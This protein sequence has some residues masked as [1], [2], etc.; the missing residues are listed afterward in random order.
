MHKGIRLGSVAGI[1]VFIDW[2]LLIIFLLIS[3]SLAAGVFP[4]WHPDWTAQV[5]WITALVAAVLFFASVLAHELA[6]ALVGRMRGIEVRRIT[7]FIFGGLAEMEHEPKAW[8]AELWMA[9]VGPLTSL[10]LGVLFVVLASLVSGPLTFDAEDPQQAFARLSPLATLLVWVGHV[11]IVLALF[12][13]V[14]GFPLD[15]GRILRALLWGW[16]GDPVRATRAAS[17]VGQAFA[18]LLILSGFAMVLGLHVPFFGTGLG[19]LWLAFIGWFLHNAA[20]VSYRQLLLRE[21]LEGVSVAQLMETDFQAVPPG[22]PVRTLVDDHLLHSGQRSFPVVE[23]DRLLGL[24][25][26][27]DVRQ[28]AKEARHRVTA[29]EIMTPLS[30]LATVAPEERAADAL[31]QLASHAYNQLPVVQGEQ[32]LGLVQREDILKW[33]ALYGELSGP[34]AEGRA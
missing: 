31:N 25:C 11:N 20:Q 7:L 10:V 14:P 18:M 29:G 33:L 24:V 13:L 8:K 5:A 23:D 32:L 34:G 3:F 28:V 21:T 22:L 1:E 30:R 12:N 17:L 15:G 2:S 6:H 4:Q 19:G 26:L 16:T 9:A 27:A